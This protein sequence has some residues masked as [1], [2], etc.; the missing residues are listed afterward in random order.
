MTFH[1]GEK[2]KTLQKTHLK[3]VSISE[4]LVTISPGATFNKNDDI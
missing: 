4:K 2:S 1:A 3:D